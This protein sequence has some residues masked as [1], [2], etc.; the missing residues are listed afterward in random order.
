MFV[1]TNGSKPKI[2][3]KYCGKHTILSEGQKEK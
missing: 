1:Q 2:H 3:L